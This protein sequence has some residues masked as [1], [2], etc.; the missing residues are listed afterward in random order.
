M[1]RVARF[2]LIVG[3]VTWLGR[4]ASALAGVIDTPIPLLGDVKVK[5][6]FIV[7]GV[8]AGIANIETQF[9]CTSLD[10]KPITVAIEV[11]DDV[12]GPPEND[13]TMTNGITVIGVGR[14]ATVE[15][16]EISSF[17]SDESIDNVTANSGS[18]RI[19]SSS[20][21]LACTALVVGGANQPTPTSMAS[22]Q[23]IKKSQKGD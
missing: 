16:N 22:L 18:A 6:V 15:T 5:T 1:T 21:K 3:V 23:V 2:A 17:Q 13:V 20:P 4:T 7:P 14:T 8:T 9:L 10:T 19:L 11:F 12:G